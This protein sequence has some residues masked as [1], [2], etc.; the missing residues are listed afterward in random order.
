[1]PWIFVWHL[2][3]EYLPFLLLVLH[4]YFSLHNPQSLSILFEENW[5]QLLADEQIT[6]V[7]PIE[8]PHPSGP[9]IQ[10]WCMTQAMPIRDEK[11]GFKTFWKQYKE[12]RAEI[13]REKKCP[14]DYV[15]DLDL[16]LPE[17]SPIFTV[18]WAN[19]FH[20]LF[21][22]VFLFRDRKEG[23]REKHQSATSRTHPDQGVNPKPR[24][25]PWPRIKPDTFCVGDDAPF[26]WATPARAK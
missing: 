9:V 15:W 14:N 26:N 4:Y 12:S 17:T 16:V 22:Q 6:R 5:P 21:K 18:T 7:W 23:K 2:C 19:Y 11:L 10:R 13:C 3:R 1:M 25:V 8:V 24:Y 20:L